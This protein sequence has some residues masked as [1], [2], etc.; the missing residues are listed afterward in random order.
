MK[1]IMLPLSLSLIFFVS[2]QGLIAESG[3]LQEKSIVKENEIRNPEKSL[4]LLKLGNQRFLNNEPL[5]DDIS[6][7]RRDELKGGQAPFATIVNCSDS[8]V[9]SSHIFNQGLGRLF[10]VKLAGNVVDEDA[11]GSIEFAVEALNTPLIVVLGHESC[12][13]VFSTVDINNNKM[14]LPETSAINS[15]VK[16]I[17]PS[18]L[19]VKEKHNHHQIKDIE[20]K[21]LVTVENARAMKNEILKNPAIKARVDKNEVKVVVAKYM[22]DGSVVWE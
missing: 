5:L 3:T 22:L 2:N 13:A 14:T 7:V 17:T 10:E 11:L 6:S 18:F 1:K 20:F 4:E 12:G 19:A 21:E 16:K 8:R 15:I 9:V